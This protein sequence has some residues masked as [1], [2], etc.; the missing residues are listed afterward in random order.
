MFGD[1]GSSFFPVCCRSLNGAICPRRH[2]NRFARDFLSRAACF[3]SSLAP[4][5]H[6]G[7]PAETTVIELFADCVQNA[8]NASAHKPSKL[9]DFVIF[10]LVLVLLPLG[11]LP[12]VVVH[13]C[14]RYETPESVDSHESGATCK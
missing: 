3:F 6:G 1:F 7:K 9:T 8:P 12:R 5:R 13:V 10:L 4:P 11:R 2:P 14:K